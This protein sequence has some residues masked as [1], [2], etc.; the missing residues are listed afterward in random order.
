MLGAKYGRL[1]IIE[2]LGI[3]NIVLKRGVSHKRAKYVKAKCECGETIEAKL[4][5]LTSLKTQSCGCL[6]KDSHKKH[7]LR[8]SPL[9]SVWSG[10]VQRC[11]NAKSESYKNYGG[12]GIFVCNEWREDFALFHEWANANGYKNSLQIDRI[13]NNN[14]Y[15]A[16]N[17][18]FVTPKENSN[19]RRNNRIICFNGE[20]KTITQWAELHEMNVSVVKERFYQLNW[21]FRKALTTPVRDENGHMTRLVILTLNGVSKPIS[22]WSKILNI[23]AETIRRR[24]FNYGWSH[25][26]A[27][28]TG[29]RKYTK[30]DT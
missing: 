6:I 21:D 14:G 16:K 4:A 2:E 1:T 26:K 22:H 20:S 30:N 29:I 19:N 15:E 5:Q 27:L 9:Y 13:D 7:G 17:C 24:I 12:R 8:Y 10:M 23:G 11:H 28:T 25:E 18:R 3:K